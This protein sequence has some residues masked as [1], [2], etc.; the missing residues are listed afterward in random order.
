[1]KKEDSK[2]ITNRFE[3]VSCLINKRVRAGMAPEKITPIIFLLRGI[4]EV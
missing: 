1:M 4:I 3:E 2:I